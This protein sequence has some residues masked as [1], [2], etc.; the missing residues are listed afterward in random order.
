MNL[1]NLI[2]AQMEDFQKNTKHE[3]VSRAYK[4][5]K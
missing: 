2:G 1:Y 4:K 3:G 5:Y